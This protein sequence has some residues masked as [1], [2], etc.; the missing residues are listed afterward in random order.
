MRGRGLEIA[1]Y[2]PYRRKCSLVVALSALITNRQSMTR[3]GALDVDRHALYRPDLEGV[4]IQSH[5]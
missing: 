2:G 5:W 3:T 1:R 4:W